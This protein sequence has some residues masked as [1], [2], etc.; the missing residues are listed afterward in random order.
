VHRLS[1]ACLILL[2]APPLRAQTALSP[3]AMADW[4]RNR[5]TVLRYIDAM[6]DSAT[7]FRPT[8]GVRSLAEQFD[9]IVTTNYEVAA[10]AVRG[11][12]AAPPLGDSTRY[13][14]D[15]AALRRYADTT[16]GYLLG[17]L[18][19]APPA[20]L[21]QP[22]ALYGQRPQPVARLAQLAFEHSVWTLGQLVPYL[23]LNGVK[24]PEYV[25]P[26]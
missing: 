15:K 25:M 14:H 8:P 23:R 12:K 22:V 13:L 17:A 5:A 21:R 3:D 4:E 19:Q 16:Y 18:R 26:F 6:P 20:R 10:I 9:H 11:L 24:P 1:L 7:G 2:A